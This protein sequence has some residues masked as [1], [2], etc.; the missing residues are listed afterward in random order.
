MLKSLSVVI[1][2]GAFFQC[3]LIKETGKDVY[4]YHTILIYIRI[5]NVMWKHC[6]KWRKRKMIKI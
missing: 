2:K 3:S 6:L 4:Y 1:N 5:E